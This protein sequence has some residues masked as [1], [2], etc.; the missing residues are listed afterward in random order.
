VAG[1]LTIR[2]VRRTVALEI[3]YLGKWKTPYNEGRV[4]R[5]GFTGRTKINR[6]DFGV[7]WNSSMENGGI[8]VGNDVDITID[9]EAILDSELRPLL[10][11]GSAR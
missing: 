9:I 6:Q 4:T 3:K 10:T 11:Q 2:G 1:E 5:V 8:V 7:S